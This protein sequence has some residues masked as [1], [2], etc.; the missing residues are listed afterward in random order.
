MTQI[1]RYTMILDWKNDYTIQ[2]CQNVYDT[3]SN[4]QIQCNP[5]QITH[6][7]F[8]R[9]RSNNPKIYMEPQKTQNYPSN[10]EEQK[11]SRGHNSPRLQA[12]LQRHSHQD[13]LA[14]VPK[15]TDQWNRRENPEINPDTYGQ[16]IFDKGG[17]NIKWRKDS[18]FSKYSWETWTAACT[19]VK[20]EHTLTACTKIKLK[21]AERLK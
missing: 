11:P 16:L 2:Y 10:P 17:K 8:H 1:E 6:D 5:Y 19:S 18:L 20:L 21:M 9:T 14:L 13:S 4:L 3:Q 15:Q 7:I 12:I